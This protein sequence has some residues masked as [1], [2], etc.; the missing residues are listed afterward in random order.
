MTPR[1]EATEPFVSFELAGERWAIAVAHVIEV[2]RAAPLTPLPL[3]PAPFAGVIPLRSRIVPALDL[4]ALL[5]L[6]A[7]GLPLPTVHLLVRRGHT[8][9][10]LLV[11]RVGDLLHIPR[12]AIHAPPDNLPPVRRARML[13]A[14]LLDDGLVGL[15][16]IE[17]TLEAAFAAPAS[18]RDA[19]HFPE[20]P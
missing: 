13:G 2:V 17:R 6:P 4:R 16:D 15:M 9:V 10:S 3:A 18:G 19:L 8:S 12:R 7:R 11:D 14:A 1:R 20:A 5:G